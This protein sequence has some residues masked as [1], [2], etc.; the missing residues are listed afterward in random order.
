MRTMLTSRLGLFICLQV[1]NRKVRPECQGLAVIC[2]LRMRSRGDSFILL[3]WHQSPKGLYD[4]L[5]KTRSSCLC[6]RHTR[7]R[8]VGLLYRY[9]SL[10]ICVAVSA[11]CMHT[12]RDAH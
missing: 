10:G 7:T 12:L 11:L 3:L 9:I 5:R 6:V 1:H 4:I 8:R 2:R